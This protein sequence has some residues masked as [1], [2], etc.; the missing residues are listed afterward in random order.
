MISRITAD[1]AVET[2]PGDKATILLHSKALTIGAA[3][4]NT[5]MRP[6]ALT[7]TTALFTREAPLEPRYFP[8]P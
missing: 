2:W 1:Y 5:A 3:F 4:A 6:M 8:P 7:L